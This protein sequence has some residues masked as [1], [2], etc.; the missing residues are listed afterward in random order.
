MGVGGRARE[1]S[2]LSYRHKDADELSRLG[3]RIATRKLVQCAGLRA[4]CCVE[5]HYW[6]VAHEATPYISRLAEK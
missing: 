2:E 4:A 3:E 6:Q 5:Q 1:Q